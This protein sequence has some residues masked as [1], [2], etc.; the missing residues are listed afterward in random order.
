MRQVMNS[1]QHREGQ[2]PCRPGS[3]C[4]LENLTI[5]LVGG[6][7]RLESRYRDAFRSLGAELLFHP[8]HCA[9]SGSNRLRAAANNADLVVFI[10]SINSHN[11]MQVVKGMCKRSGKKLIIMRET[12]PDRVSRGIADILSSE[13]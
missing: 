7:D 13:T 6:L 10:T 11:A 12:G 8:G 3:P 5:A 1:Q 4:R 2:C 9:G